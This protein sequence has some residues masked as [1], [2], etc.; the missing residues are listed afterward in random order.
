MTR[1]PPQVT[2]MLTMTKNVS[3]DDDFDV[4]SSSGDSDESDHISQQD[5]ASCPSTV[6]TVINVY[7]I[8]L[9]SGNAGQALLKKKLVTLVGEYFVHN[10]IHMTLGDAR[11]LEANMRRVFPLEQEE[12]WCDRFYTWFTN[13]KTREKKKDKA[14]DIPNSK[15]S[16]NSNGRQ[17]LQAALGRHHQKSESP[18][19]TASSS[20]S[21]DWPLRRYGASDYAPHPTGIVLR[22]VGYYTIPSLD[23]LKSYLAEDG[24]CVVP[25]FTIGREGYGTVFFAM[26]MDVA[27]LNLDE[28]VYFR[29]KG[30][31]IYPDDEKRPPINQGLNRE[32]Q[33]TLEQVWP[34]NK[35]QTQPVL[36]VKDAQ[37]LIEMNWE[38]HL[39]C[40]C[41]ANDTRFVE[42]RPETGSWVFCVKHFS[43]YGL[44]EDDDKMTLH[45]LRPSVYPRICGTRFRGR[46]L[47]Q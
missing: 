39:R 20:S 41:Y 29:N 31:I 18:T 38:G 21:S 34:V 19:E 32:A 43:K 17:R 6:T 24:S 4:T 12:K 46:F 37:R 7:G 14:A 47:V 13:R 9:N 16:V 23:D 42:Y 2:T 8:L 3:S 10:N 5:A 15:S 40:A 36:V 27:G 28:I 25:N 44:D 33:V 35:T 26:E 22:R 1:P 30:I 45:S 11:Y